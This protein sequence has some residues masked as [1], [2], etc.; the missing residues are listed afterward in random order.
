MFWSTLKAVEFHLIQLLS[1]NFC[2]IYMSNDVKFFETLRII[3]VIFCNLL[4]LMLHVSLNVTNKNY[5][6]INTQSHHGYKQND[7]V[8]TSIFLCFA[9]T[10][11]R[12]RE[13]EL[14]LI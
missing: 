9:L 10:R 4:V 12:K 6:L 13:S 2:N 3:V 1:F 5:Q 7:Q 14:G 11:Y 8:L